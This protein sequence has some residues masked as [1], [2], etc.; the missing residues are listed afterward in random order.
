MKRNNLSHAA[1]RLSQRDHFL[2]G[3]LRRLQELCSTD[4]GQLAQVFSV[5][6]EKLDLLALCKA[7]RWDE[8]FSSDVRAIAEFSSADTMP[9]ANGLRLLHIIDTLGQASQSEES[10]LLAAARA[11]KEE[12]VT[13]NAIPPDPAMQ[14]SWI[15]DATAL[16]LGEDDLWSGSHFPR[17]L[18]LAIVLHLPLAIVELPGLS[19]ALVVE[20]LARHGINLEVHLPPQGLRGAL[21]ANGGSGVLFVGADDPDDERRLTLA[22]EAAHF[23]LDYW[24]P[25]THLAQR[26]PQL[27]EVLDGE[28]VATEDDFVDGLLANARLGFQTH[29]FERDHSGNAVDLELGPIEERATL[30]AWELLA[31]QTCVWAKIDTRNSFALTRLLEEEFGLPRIAAREYGAFLQRTTTNPLRDRFRFEDD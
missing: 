13:D 23:V 7:P 2:A 20:W 5:D 30:A 11:T 31:P 12:P 9:L 18:E 4:W 16:I 29:L 28:R 6:E 19:G 15:D 25:R 10:R 22:H 27:L 21:V 8:H 1:D 17:D 24:L 14:A 26:A 3:S